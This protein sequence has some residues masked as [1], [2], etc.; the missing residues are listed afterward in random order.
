MSRYSSFNI[1]F[2]LTGRCWL[3]VCLILFSFDCFHSYGQAPDTTTANGT[4]LL[5]VD[6][7]LVTPDSARIDSL[8]LGDD[9]KSKVRY[10]AD[11][12]TVYDLLNDKVY[13]YG[14]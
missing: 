12:S 8:A 10:T 14:N 7:S 2:L 11:D 3:L 1:F 5:P 4:L 6:S 9:F 13:L